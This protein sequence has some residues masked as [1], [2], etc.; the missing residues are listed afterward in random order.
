MNDKKELTE[1]I[2]DIVTLELGLNTS[3][4]Y[5]GYMETENG[6]KT[7][8]TSYLNLNIGY[9]ELMDK[10]IF[11]D[12]TSYVDERGNIFPSNASYTYI[13]MEKENLIEILGEDGYIN[14]ISGSGELI[15]T[16]NKDNLEYKFEVANIMFETS[17]PKTE[18]I[19]RLENG[20]EIKPLE[21]SKAQI[22]KFVSYR[23]N[24]VTNI[25]KDNTIIIRGM[26]SKD[27]SL[28]NPE[29]KAELTIN[30]PNI[31]TVIKNE[32]VELR[33]TL[34]STDSSSMLYK[35]PKLEIVLPSYV[36]TINIE[37]V[38]LLYEKELV[39]TNANMYRN[40][41]GNIVIRVE[42]SGSQTKYNEDVIAE[43]ATLVMEADITA[44]EL[45]PSK[46]EKVYLNVVNENE[47]EIR[48]FETEMKFIAP[49]GMVTVNQISNYNEKAENATAISGK[50]EVGEIDT[51]AGAKKAL[52]SM[53]VINNYDYE[54]NNIRIL[55]RTPFAGNKSIKTGQD[56]GS[57]F[58]AKV[59]SKIEATLGVRN[60]DITV[61]YSSN[62]RSK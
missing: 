8:F 46:T 58:T 35:N 45:T 37:N 11:K 62:R 30:K 54:C 9:S 36:K 4:L 3:E 34:K 60:E 26:D 5:K 51:Y 61:Y 32:A 25:S 48:S 56:L 50:K 40:E 20:R 17:K 15:T 12:E 41:N 44:D 49:T 39:L 21:Y 52:V 22:E 59:V 29:T 24:L 55:G 13:K 7:A 57:T 38:K 53:R 16:I 2:G 6:K 14:V 28:K 10:L 33:V 47:D 1:Q 19:L 27:I 42:L 18:G 23:V 31:S 43:G